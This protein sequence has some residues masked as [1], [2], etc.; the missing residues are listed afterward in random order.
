MDPTNAAVARL[1]ALAS[2]HAITPGRS[3]IGDE[4][5]WNVFLRMGTDGAKMDELREQKNNYRG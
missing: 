1:E 2:E 3:T 4:R 5:E